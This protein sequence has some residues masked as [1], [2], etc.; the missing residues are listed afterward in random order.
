MIV[1]INAS[2]YALVAILLI[3]IEEK[4]VY[5]VIFHSYT[6]KAAEFNYNIHDKKLLMVFEAFYTWYHYLEGSE[7]PIDIITDH[8]NLEY[9]STTKIFFHYQAK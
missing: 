9:L 7:L 8:K 6:F 1:E 3:I 2:N 5:L 4:E